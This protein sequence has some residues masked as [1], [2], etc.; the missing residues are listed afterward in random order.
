MRNIIRLIQKYRNVLFFLL[1]ELIALSFLF[2]WRNSY[3]S[4]NYLNSSN[5]VSA[6][7]FNFKYG[8][9]SYFKL[10][11]VNDD[12]L[13]ENALLKEHLLN[14]ELKVGKRYVKLE[15]SLYYKNYVFIEAK[16]INSQFKFAENNLLINKGKLNGVSLKMGL[17]GTKGVYGIIENVSDHY[18]SVKPLIHEKFGLTVI[19]QKTKTLGDF[20]WVPGENN[21]RTAYVENI[22][23]YAKIK[24]GDIFFTTGS[25]G[26]F[27]ENI[28]VGK[29]IDIAENKEKQTLKITIELQEDFSS[30]RVGYVVKNLM[31][32]EIN[33]FYTN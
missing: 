33:E 11:E 28:K 17:I 2:S 29:V 1:L 15:D 9:I 27:P 25:D 21:F 3:H 4:S 32:E 14:K 23:I 13:V 5:A 20:R 10:K 8:I 16:I 12:L 31:S 26:V 6:S 18:A 22:P 30:A 24:L 7:L 19:H